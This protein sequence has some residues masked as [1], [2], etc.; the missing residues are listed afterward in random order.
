VLKLPKI[1]K[2]NE[3]QRM[4]NRI[5]TK[6]P[7]GL[8]NMVALQLMYRAGLRNSE[9]CNLSPADID[10]DKGLIYIQQSKGRKDRYAIMDDILKGWCMK[11]DKVRPQCDYYVCTMKGTKLS[12]RYLREICYRLSKKAGVYINDNHRLR[13]VF[14]HALRHT[15][16]TELL[17]SKDFNIREVQTLLGHSNVNTT[18]IYTHVVM[19]DLLVEKIKNRR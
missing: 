11:W 8:R 6:T 18:M 13:K 16:A 1:V 9:V 14:P 7:S 19:D 3:L 5:N 17:A 4:F 15:F 12:D 10:M 2:K